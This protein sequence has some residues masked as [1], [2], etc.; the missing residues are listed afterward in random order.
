MLIRTR[1]EER[2]VGIECDT[3]RQ[4]E[5]KTTKT[6]N[7]V[8]D[9]L[10]KQYIQS[11]EAQKTR[12]WGIEEKEMLEEEEEKVEAS[13]EHRRAGMRAINGANEESEDHRIVLEVDVV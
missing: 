3:Q 7:T 10:R 4:T 8:T 1:K 2:H 12:G 11:T 9:T 5:Q 13:S 6:R